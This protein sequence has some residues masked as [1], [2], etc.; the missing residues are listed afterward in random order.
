VNL[1]PAL[2]HDVLAFAERFG[3]VLYPWQ[4]EAFA[5]ACRRGAGRFV[6]RPAGAS[7]PRG[8][9]KCYGGSLVGA[10]A[11]VGLWRLLCGRPPQDIISAA[12]DLDGSRIVP[13]HARGIIRG[14]PGLA[15]AVEVQANSLLVPSTRSRWT[16]TGRE[17]TASRGRRPTVVLY[18]EIGWARDDEGGRGTA[19]GHGRAARSSLCRWHKKLA[20][21]LV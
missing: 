4:R 5:A 11:V 21:E 19:G 20:V 3:V 7:V 16:I 6:H 12:L 2:L 13:D 17:H 10:L 14:R 8:N 15:G 18:D 1:A 9:G